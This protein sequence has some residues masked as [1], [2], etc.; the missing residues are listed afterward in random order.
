MARKL[1]HG[2]QAPDY[3]LNDNRETITY[4]DDN[5]GKNHGLKAVLSKVKRSEANLEAEGGETVLGEIDGTGKMQHAK[6]VGKPHSKGGVPLNL[7]QGTFIFSDNQELAVTDP[8]VLKYFGVEDKKG[9]GVTPAEIAKKF[10][11]NKFQNIVDDFQNNNIARGSAQAMLDKNLKNLFSLAALQENMKVEKAPKPK[12]VRVKLPEF[13]KGGPN[14]PGDDIEHVWTADEFNSFLNEQLF[15]NSN[16]KPIN[17]VLPSTQEVASTTG[18]NPGM[19]V[20]PNYAGDQNDRIIQEYEELVTKKLNTIASQTTSAPKSKP[21]PNVK[22]KLSDDNTIILGD[23][24]TPAEFFSGLSS[25][26]S[27]ANVITTGQDIPDNARIGKDEN[28]NYVAVDSKGNVIAAIELDGGSFA[29]ESLKTFQKR[30]SL[31]PEQIAGREAADNY[32]ASTASSASSTAASTS[33]SSS[34][35]SSS[36]PPVR[37]EATKVDNLDVGDRDKLQGLE[38]EAP[39]ELRKTQSD[40]PV[41]EDASSESTDTPSVSN[42][43]PWWAQDMIALAG[44]LTDGVNRYDPS[45]QQ[46]GFETIRNRRVS[47]DGR[48]AARQSAG[49]SAIN[50]VENTS[51]GQVARANAMA[52]S[53][54]IAEGA[55]QD[56][57]QVDSIN[58]S[59]ESQTRAQNAQITNQ[60]RMMNAQLRDDYNTKMARTLQNADDAQREL[61]QRRLKALMNGMT[62]ADNTQMLNDMYP[63][64]AVDPTTGRISMTEGRDLDDPTYKSGNANDALVNTYFDTYEKAVSK[65]LND[66]AAKEAASLAI[67]GATTLGR[68]QTRMDGLKVL[69]YL[70]SLQGK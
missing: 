52:I 2:H 43:A 46:V 9:K 28:G 51:D 41:S 63:N 53:G 1:K 26:L 6:V 55:S 56:Q 62:N 66:D 58:A 4:V 44:A 47:A 69:E 40:I 22:Y 68:E 32:N 19:Y 45:M 12:K 34:A 17:F 29:S 30:Y 70:K 15:K 67:R 37:R 35:A 48:I 60:G 8:E 21:I 50:T 65:G 7:P 36:A 23:N 59:L 24:E 18:V 33:A 14:E 10:E 5:P 38:Y 42:S 64:M 49:E 39:T 54:Q 31:T 20:D 13:S 57:G 16:E 25:E 61:K 11:V 3:S 27:G